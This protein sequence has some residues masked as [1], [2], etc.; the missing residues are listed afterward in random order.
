MREE[1][2]SNLLKTMTLALL[3]LSVGPSLLESTGV[4]WGGMH[5]CPMWRSRIKTDVLTAVILAC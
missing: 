5:H 1:N 4:G 3:K 2:H